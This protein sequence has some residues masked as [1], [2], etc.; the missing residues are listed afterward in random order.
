MSETYIR[1]FSSPKPNFRDLDQEIWMGETPGK[2][3]PSLTL[4]WKN[5]KILKLLS[6]GTFTISWDWRRS[7]RLKFQRPKIKFHYHCVQNSASYFLYSGRYDPSKLGFQ[8]LPGFIPK[9]D[10]WGEFLYL[11]IQRSK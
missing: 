9:H 8:P 7:K 3:N 4:S 2:S 11:G 1:F 5:P 10:T 6:F